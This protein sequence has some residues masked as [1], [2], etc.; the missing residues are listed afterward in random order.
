MP[1]RYQDCVE[2]AVQHRQPQWESEKQ[3][4]GTG[5]AEVGGYLLGLWG[6]PA[7]LVEAVT[8][9]HQPRLRQ[10]E[11]FSPVTAVPLADQNQARETPANDPPL[12]PALDEAHLEAVGLKGKLDL[13]NL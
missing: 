4:L 9:H 1:R 11:E 5:H 12:I 3:V 7:S 8:W 10:P 13:V 2:A 6:L